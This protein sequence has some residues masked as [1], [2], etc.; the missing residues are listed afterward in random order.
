[1]AAPLLAATTS[2]VLGAHDTQPASRPDPLSKIFE[3]KI[4][5][6]EGVRGEEQIQA[7]RIRTFCRGAQHVHPEPR[8]LGEVAHK[9]V[10]LREL[11]R[12]Q[13]FALQVVDPPDFLAHDQTVRAAGET[14]LDRGDHLEVAAVG[15]QHVHRGGGGRDA[16]GV[17]RGPAFLLG[18]LDAQLEAVLAEEERVLRRL[19]AAVGHDDAGVARVFTQLEIDDVVLRHIRGR[20]RQQRAGVERCD[21]IGRIERGVTTV[22]GRGRRTRAGRIAPGDG[23]GIQAVPPLVGAQAGGAKNQQGQ[24]NFTEGRHGQG[25]EVLNLRFEI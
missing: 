20:R 1:M 8:L 24:Y 7:F 18:E 21:E 4:T 9:E 25:I 2:V 5:G 22:F 16:A 14:D 13:G 17:E 19:Q 10:G 23:G 15:G 11:G 3:E 12:D 6:G